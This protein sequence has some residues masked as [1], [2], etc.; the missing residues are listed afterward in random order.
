M[1]SAYMIDVLTIRYLATLDQWN[2]ASYLDVSVIG[3]IEWSDRLIRN[4]R[5][6]QVV[7][8]ALVYLDGSVTAPTNADRIFIDGKEHAIMRVDKKTDFSTSHFEIWIS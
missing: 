5:G 1:I 3:R 8:A 7:S 4:S 2:S 6:E